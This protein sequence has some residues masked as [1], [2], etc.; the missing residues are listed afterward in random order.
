MMFDKDSKFR[1]FWGKTE[2]KD[3]FQRSVAERA[4]ATS[5]I[6]IVQSAAEL[7]ALY[8]ANV[9]LVAAVVKAWQ[10]MSDGSLLGRAIWQ[11][12]TKKLLGALG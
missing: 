10:E 11:V 7:A 1:K 6:S 2:L 12:R 5:L 9:D 3:T 4:Y 8:P